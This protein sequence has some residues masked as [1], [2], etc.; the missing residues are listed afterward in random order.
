[1]L[2]P[3]IFIIVREYKVLVPPHV[4]ITVLSSV[5]LKSMGYSINDIVTPFGK[6]L[7]SNDRIVESFYDKIVYED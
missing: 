6:N 4:V 3:T 5:V 1:M 7:K 2:V